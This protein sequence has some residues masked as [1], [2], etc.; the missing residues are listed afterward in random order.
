MN[1]QKRRFSRYKIT[2]FLGKRK[3]KC[4]L[5]GSTSS[6]KT[7]FNKHWKKSHS[8]NDKI[9]FENFL[10]INLPKLKSNI[11]Y[12]NPNSDFDDSPK[13]LDNKMTKIQVNKNI[14]VIKN[15]N[16]SSNNKKYIGLKKRRKKNNHLIGNEN[17]LNFDKI[18]R[19]NN[20]LKFLINLN[21][22]QLDNIKNNTKFITN[23]NGKH[24]EKFLFSCNVGI[25]KDKNFISSHFSQEK[26]IE[27]N[28]SECISGI[29]GKINN[30]YNIVNLNEYLIFINLVIGSGKYKDVYFGINKEKNLPVIIKYFKGADKRIEEFEAEINIIKDIQNKYLFPKII[31]NFKFNGKNYLIE[32][33]FGPDLKKFVKFVGVNNLSKSTIYKIG[34]DLFY[35]LKILHGKGYLHRDLKKDNIVSLC[36]PIWMNDY[37]INFTLIDFGFS[38]KFKFSHESLINEENFVYGW[39]NSY[40]ASANALEKNPIGAKDDLIAAC[41]ILLNLCTKNALPW[42]NIQGNDEKSLRRKIVLL[43]KSFNIDDYIDKSYKE[44]IDIY[45]EIISMNMNENPNYDR[46]IMILKEYIFENEN[47]LENRNDFDW[48]KKIRLKIMKYNRLREKIE[49]DSEIRKLFQGYPEEIISLFLNKY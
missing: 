20:D 36:A 16:L 9:L 47:G 42:E 34:I 4:A 31:D 2:S 17:F 7:N 43:K 29:L 40:Y 46:Y 14:S 23:N 44:I 32:N 38:L 24:K 13:I 25:N 27:Q 1:F 26:N 5:C 30:K 15:E 41:Y 12:H 49:N 18:E 19:K 10:K 28:L 11:L 21:I 45:K 37:F 48:S 39:G 22:T 33:M 3:L 8:K 6:N 35:N